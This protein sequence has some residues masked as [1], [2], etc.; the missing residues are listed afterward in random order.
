MP[1]TDLTFLREFCRNDQKKMAQYIRIFLESVPE[2]SNEL[3]MGR[4]E[5]NLIQLRRTAHALKPQV[6]FLGL[7]GLKEQ[8]EMLED[9][10]DSSK[11][12]SEIEP[13][14]EDLQLILERATGDLV[15]S[16]LMLS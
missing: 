14:L 8:I 11:N 2:I 10:I 15:E 16:L 1:N 4:K 9:Q 13:M 6:T 12:Y 5:Q 3:E 7:Q